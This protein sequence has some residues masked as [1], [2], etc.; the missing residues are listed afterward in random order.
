M[1]SP[2]SNNSG[3][4]LPHVRGDA[5]LVNRHRPETRLLRV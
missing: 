2:L 5:E 4:G 3:D 1:S